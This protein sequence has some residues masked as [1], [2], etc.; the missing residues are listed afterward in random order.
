MAHEGL[1]ALTLTRAARAGWC[2]RGATP[3]CTT[4]CLLSLEKA[5]TERSA[6]PPQLPTQPLGLVQG[7]P[8]SGACRTPWG[9]LR[10]DL[11]WCRHEASPPWGQP[12]ARAA[13][14]LHT[15]AT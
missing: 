14:T 12:Q 13:Q 5:N 11:M 3:C 4:P 7:A 2:G 10:M 9:Q 6:W 8:G 1:G 15:P